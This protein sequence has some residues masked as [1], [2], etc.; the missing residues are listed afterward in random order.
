MPE[1]PPSVAEPWTCPSCRRAIATPYCS[2]CG[3]RRRD[4]RDLTLGGLL[5]QAFEAFTNIDGRVL[6]SFRWL[7]V[8]PGSLTVAFVEG[9]RKPFLGPVALFLVA[10]VV[11]FGAESLTSGLVFSTPLSSHLNDQPWSP[12]AQRLVADRLAASGAPLASF[13]TRFDAAIALH[14]RSMI[15]L[16][17]L[18]FAPLPALVFRRRG[19]PFAA[20]VVFSLHLYAFTLL[21]LSIG[22]P[23]PNV[24]VLFGGVRSTSRLLD[25]VL[26]ISLLIACAVYLYAAIGA[27][28]G[29]GRTARVLATIV[30]TMAA[31]A[32]VLAYRFALFLL[33]L[34]TT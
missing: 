23:V 18:A 22:T 8:S 16:M 26:S 4:P 15:L 30:L 1:V 27:V 19:H 13:A 31:A 2:T 14:A 5:N 17:A 7:L 33:T 12:L 24:P 10:N 20:H 11:F 34:Y 25:G 28:Y 32:I 3:E 9:R 29:G 6:R 21:I